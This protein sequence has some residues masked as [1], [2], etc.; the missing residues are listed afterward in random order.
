MCNVELYRRFAVVSNIVTI[1][2]VVQLSPERDA[3]TGNE[4]P[5]AAWR[6]NDQQT[7]QR[8]LTKSST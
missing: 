4:A 3:V 7:F 6:A 2:S 8:S 5:H 1:Q